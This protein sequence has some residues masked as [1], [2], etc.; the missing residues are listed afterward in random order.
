MR[1]LSRNRGVLVL[2]VGICLASCRET[3]EQPIEW[4]TGSV[5]SADGV[6]I[7]YQGAGEGPVSLV[8]VHG[9]SCDRSYWKEQLDYFARV[10]RVVALDLAG[11]GDSGLNRDDW[12]FAA[13]GEDVAAV[14]NGLGLER[15]VLVGHS[16]GGPV[17]LEAARIAPQ[18]VIGLVAVDAL[19]DPDA[20]SMTPEA[21]QVF[22]GP[23]EENFSDAMRG[24]IPGAMFVPESDPILK[25][26]IVEDM[27]SA[28]PDVGIGAVRGNMQWP[29]TTRSEAL[30]ALQVPMRLIN[31]PMYRTDSTAVRRY[32]MDVVIM[33]GVGHF[34]MLEDPETFNAL[35]S[36]AIA[37][38]AN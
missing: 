3:P 16:M 10:H 18:E 27:A 26:W 28:P 1:L 33:S 6:L 20:P 4:V 2:A 37:G 5:R 34:A 8:F 13:F 22:L 14:I 21:I 31:S 12:T 32:G 24:L 9:W 11:H 29:S 38:F 30:A 35:L 7:S 25:A 15:I 17:I 19:Q 36:S 23:F